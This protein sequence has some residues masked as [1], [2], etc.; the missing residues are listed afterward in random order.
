[1]N[2]DLEFNFYIQMISQ[3]INRLFEAGLNNFFYSA[4]GNL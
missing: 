2:V 4:F 1:M 3:N